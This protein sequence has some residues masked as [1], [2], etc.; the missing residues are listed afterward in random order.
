MRLLGTKV[1]GGALRGWIR[2]SLAILSAAITTWAL[3]VTQ[4][5]WHPPGFARSE[6]R[7]DEE[8]PDPEIQALEAE[9]VRIQSRLDELRSRRDP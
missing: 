9:L 7:T 1:E 5:T 4:E 6:I 3:Y 2:V 8:T